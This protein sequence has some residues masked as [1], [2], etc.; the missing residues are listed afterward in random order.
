MSF[1]L[2]PLAAGV[3]AVSVAAL[4]AQPPAAPGPT[5]WPQWRGPNRDGKSAE[6]GL[7]KSW[8]KDGPPKLWTISGLGTGYSTPTVAAGMIFVMGTRDGKDCVIGLKESDGKA[9]WFTPLD[10]TKNPNQNNGPGGSPTY[11]DGKLYAVSNVGTLAALDANTG[12]GLW[13]RSYTKEFGAGVP[14]WG[15]ND[16]P[17]VDG[18]KLICAPSGTKGAVAALNLKTGATVW[19]TLLPQI[20]GGAGYSSP[21]KMT[22]GGIPTYVQLLGDKSGVVG[23]HADTGKLLWQYK[24]QGAIGSVAQ[25]PTPVIYENKVWVSCS[26]TKPGGAAL[27]EL[28]PVGKDKIEVK[29]IKTYEKPELN[30]HHGG[31]ILVGKHVFFGHEQNKAFPACVDITTG[32]IAYK[33]EKMP[34]GTSGSVAITFA[35]GRLY[36]RFQNH[37]LALVEPDP[38]AFKM[39]SSFRLPEP[40]NKESWA[41]PVVANG[42][43]YIRDQDKLHCFNLKASTN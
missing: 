38:T 20:G 33:E 16:S 8:P 43:L 35:D 41:H 22:V 31:M 2:L 26:Y 37:V 30:N 29:T 1:R 24:E 3:L 23:V 21:V 4:S 40:S 18:N 25:I 11:H 9:L 10:P 28:S 12:R 5:D 14:S 6:T 39:V 34:P 19:T 15:F 42:K 17:L 27:L 7:L 32:E 36:Y 13:T